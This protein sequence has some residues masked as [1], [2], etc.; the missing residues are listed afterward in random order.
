MTNPN[1]LL[2]L[3]EIIISNISN[4]KFNVTICV[5]QNYVSIII[6]HNFALYTSEEV[7]LTIMPKI[8]QKYGVDSHEL[9]KSFSKISDG[10]FLIYFDSPFLSNYAE[11]S[12]TEAAKD[13]LLKYRVK[14]EE[15]KYITFDEVKHEDGI[16]IL[17]ISLDIG[18]DEGED[19]AIKKHKDFLE[20]KLT[21]ELF[22]KTYVDLT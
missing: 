4:A 11:Q 6:S 22:V 9:S 1:H 3:K 14:Q 8:C 13:L 20:K 19:F 10:T 21:E 2:Q 17:N 18:Y 12:I 5:L 7:F 16:G 15:I